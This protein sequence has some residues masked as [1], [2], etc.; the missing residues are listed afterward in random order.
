MI[1]AGRHT[2][3]PE[4]IHCFIDLAIGNF[5]SIASGLRIISGQHPPIEHPQCVSTFPF[6]EH[7]WGDYPPSRMDGKVTVGS[8]VW[9]GQD[10]AILDGVTV[11]HGAS[12]GACSVVTRDVP[13]YSVVAGNPARVIRTRFPGSVVAA[14]LRVA[15]WDWTDD[16]IRAALPWMS[17]V[18]RFLV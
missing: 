12:V 7:G 6:A 18:G 9:I 3:V 16:E 4:D 11:G 1:Q 2:I 17:D 10:V 8:D 5:T 14:L 13:P 15:W